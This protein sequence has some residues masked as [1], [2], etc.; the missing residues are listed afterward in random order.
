MNQLGGHGAFITTVTDNM[1]TPAR[2]HQVVGNPGNGFIRGE[3]L[4]KGERAQKQEQES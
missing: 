2:A 3:D 4:S 1:R